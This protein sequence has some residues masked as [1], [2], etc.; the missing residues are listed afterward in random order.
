MQIQHNI[1]LQNLNTMATSAVAKWFVVA[2]TEDDILSAM[3]FCQQQMCGHLV[4]GE[5]SNSL[6]VNDQDVLIIANRI[7]GAGQILDVFTS[8]AITT[9]NESED[10]IELRIGAGVNWHQLV[11]QSLEHGYYGLEQLALIPGLVG[12]APIQ[13]I[14]A[15][16][17]E[18]KDSLIAVRAFDTS[19]RTFVELSNEDCQFMYRDSIFKQDS[20]RYIITAVDLHL[21]KKMPQ[22]QLE[23]IYTGLKSE[24]AN[25]HEITA[26]DIFNAVC[27]VRQSKLPDPNFIP[28]AGSFFKNPIVSVDQEQALKQ[29]FPDLVSYPAGDDIKIAA[30]WLIDRIGLKGYSQFDGVGCYEKQALVVVNHN[31]ASGEAVINFAQSIQDKVKSTYDVMLEIEPRIF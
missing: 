7:G 2:Q 8:K 21:L 22:Y 1:Q 26:Q 6:F 3:D 23:D 12:A 10:F 29:R 31:K 14:G 13:N 18:I 4:F 28:N 25:R 11:K 9:L 16:G 30:G 17:S 19:T 24:L 20:T 15:Y 5:G 27:K